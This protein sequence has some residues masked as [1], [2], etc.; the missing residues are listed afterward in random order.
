MK[1]I[2]II[3]LATL[4]LFACN[5]K[6]VPRAS[7]TLDK[8]V[9]NLEIGGTRMLYVSFRPKSMDGSALTW[10]SMDSSIATVSD[11][12]VTGINLGTTSILVEYGDIVDTCIVTVVSPA[13][14]KITL[15][16]TN[17]E[18]YE[19]EI[20]RIKANVFPEG[21]TDRLFWSSSDSSIV[22]VDKNGTVKALAAGRA[23]IIATCRNI[24]ADCNVNSTYPL[25]FEAIDAGTITI[26]NPLTRSIDYKINESEQ[27][28]CSDPTITL[29]VCSGD[30]VRLYGKA[31][32]YATEYKNTNILCSSKCYIYGSIM[33]LS[34]A[35]SLVRDKTISESNA[36]W[37]LFDGNVNIVNHPDK[38]ILLPAT[39]LAPHCYHELFFNCT[40]LTSAPELPAKTIANACYVNMFK[41]CSGITV[42]P[43]LPA[44]TLSPHCYVGMFSGCSSLTEAPSLPARTLEP[45]C[46]TDMFQYCTSLTSAP[47]LPATQI[48]EN[49]YQGM[50][51]GCSKLIKAP[52]LKASKMYTDCYR[53]MFAQCSELSEPPLLP[54]TQLAESCY[55]VMFAGCSKLKEAPVLP[56][57]T[58]AP[59]CYDYMFQHCTSL[60]YLKAMFTSD[61]TYC[62]TLWVQDVSPEGTFI[63]SR[64]AKW[65]V[66][67]DSGIPLGWTVIAE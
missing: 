16:I 31:K 22:S 44:T 17:L 25:S 55:C 59:H 46:Y 23:S 45:Y 3:C 42:A 56:A 33:S 66:T 19:G 27:A 61:P 29:D 35:G 58:L 11:G 5:H 47:V 40:G 41:W 21:V 34:D 15:D 20:V 26:K 53:G 9:L 39:T 32:S 38:D 48:A 13:P 37:G 8:H 63:K 7:I 62:I 43:N 18:L 51:F 10:M 4:S 67:G 1:R 30:R 57:A 60:N 65:D 54:S 14:K 6:E 24:S 50:F 12:L 64:D 2:L 49:C 28:S 36:F 52:E